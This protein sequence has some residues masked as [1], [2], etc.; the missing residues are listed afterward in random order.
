MPEKEGARN[1]GQFLAISDAPDFCKTPPNMAPVPYPNIGKLDQCLSNSPN[2]K[3]TGAMAVLMGQS[4]VPSV[5]GNEAGVGGGVKSGVNKSNVKFTKGSG[6][7]KVNGKQVMRDRDPVSM[8]NGNTTGKVVCLT[9][10][11]PSGG[12]SPSGQPTQPPNPPVKKRWERVKDWLRQTGIEAI[13]AERHPIEGTIGAAKNEANSGLGI[14]H[15][16]YQAKAQEN[17]DDMRFQGLITGALGDKVGAE[18]MAQAGDSIEE[19]SKGVKLPQFELTND[20]QK[21]GAKICTGAQVI[22]GVAELAGGA[23]KGV[24]KLASKLGRTEA[25]AAVAGEAAL[26]RKAEASTSALKSAEGVAAEEKT[27][28]KA[29]E[30]PGDGVRVKKLLPEDLK[31]TDNQSIREWYNKQVDPDRITELNKNWEKQGLSCEERAK[32]TFDIRHDARIKARGFMENPEEVANLRARDLQKYGNPDGPTFKQ[33]VDKYAARGLEGD[34]VYHS[35]IKGASRTDAAT[36]A[37]F[38]IKR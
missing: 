19:I 22:M 29:V 34:D 26:V 16:M 35:I 7:V 3:F 38:G 2:V 28:V 14:L 32:R 30:S 37:K 25:K 6:T 27:V 13:E 12:I 23:S 11:L 33:E 17:A 4:E 21:G 24:A 8:N 15:G 20:A 1:S 18:K 9:P 10:S 5:I 31:G 36:N